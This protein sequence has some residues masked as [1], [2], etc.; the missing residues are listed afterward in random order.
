MHP[1]RETN[2]FKTTVVFFQGYD[3]RVEHFHCFS[4]HG[5]GGHYHFDV[6]PKD[7]EYRGYFVLAESI[8]R[9]D[10]PVKT[11]QLGRWAV[12]VYYLLK[13]WPQHIPA[14]SDCSNSTYCDF[15]DLWLTLLWLVL[16]NMKSSYIV[17]MIKPIYKMNK[18]YIQVWFF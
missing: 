10:Q 17:Q 8:Y 12:I 14:M 1:L 11:T 7:V 5:Q 9:I 15:K 3:L 16:E 6:T 4:D 18:Q 2:N 13:C